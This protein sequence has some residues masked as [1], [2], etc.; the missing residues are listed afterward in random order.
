MVTEQRDLVTKQILYRTHPTA[1]HF[2]QR[3]HTHTHRQTERERERER[4]AGK[5]VETGYMI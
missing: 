2:L 5:E 1:K 4:E 3:T